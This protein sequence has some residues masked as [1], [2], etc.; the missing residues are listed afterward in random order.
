MRRATA[1]PLP[2]TPYPPGC[3]VLQGRHGQQARPALSFITRL[4]KAGDEFPRGKI[5]QAF[6]DGGGGMSLQVQGTATIGG[7]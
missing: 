2:D 1:S 7:W 4:A 3:P 5:G 6:I